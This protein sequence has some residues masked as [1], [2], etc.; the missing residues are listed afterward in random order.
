V[1]AAGF[2]GG[3]GGGTDAGGGGG[4]G[5][6]G[7]IF[8]VQG[9]SLTVINATI[10]EGTV[11]RGAGGS[12]TN[13]N[14]ADGLAAGSG[15]YLHG[16][17]SVGFAPTSASTIADEIAGTGNLE[18][19]GTATL[20]LSAT[21]TYTGSTTIN[22]GTLLVSGSIAASSLTSVASGA[23]LGGSG[24]AGAV[25]VA[26][27]G[28]LS[29][30]ASAGILATGNLTFDAG[31]LLRVELGGTAAGIGGYDQLRITGT[32]SL[33]G[34]TLD[35][36]LIGGFN[37]ATAPGAAY[38]IIDNDGADAVSGAF[39]GLAEG[40]SISLGG[41]ALTISYHGGDG[42]DV[43]L[44]APASI[45]PPNLTEVVTAL[46]STTVAAGGSFSLAARTSNIGG[47]PTISGSTSRIF[48]S[49]DAVIDP[50]DTVLQ[51][52]T[53]PTLYAGAEFAQNYV[54][55]LP[56][57]LAPG[58]YY[59]GGL[60]DFNNQ[61]GEGNEGDNNYN[62]LAITVT[63]APPAPPPPAPDLRAVVTALTDT[64]VAAG[65]MFSFALNN[66]NEGSV[67]AAGSTT[68][69]FLSS[70]PIITG[71][72]TVL[73]I[74]TVAPLNPGAGAAQ[75]F[76][77][78]LPGNLA[79]GTW[80]IG[81][82]ADYH[83]QISESNEANNNGNLLTMTVL[84]P[85]LME[86]EAAA[87]ATCWSGSQLTEAIASSFVETGGT[88][89]GQVAHTMAAEPIMLAASTMQG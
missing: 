44:A 26:S 78:N 62:R 72:D 39:T 32:V 25:T 57:N 73:A 38:R 59:V 33:A 69:V 16:T 70:D 21:N 82:L 36:S 46:S 64:T 11:A 81:A 61:V 35:T 89:T 68:R 19:S 80:Y 27:G 48:L 40:A 83:N 24:S 45:A 76:V 71:Q 7:S 12:G 74:Q 5:Y 42:N 9:G 67:A 29:P 60:A 13:Q 2:G 3:E 55:N 14:G 88:L 20:T 65:G 53:V 51:I 6:G 54:V 34:A 63:A 1:A 41:I 49:S 8:V 50:L 66:V 28:T 47:G 15:I 87:S 75:N 52:R 30:G 43:V 84:A 77:V 58:T 23:T 4:S 10:S 85:S 17:S 22:G 18:M 56:A 31:A 37:L 86:N 79:P